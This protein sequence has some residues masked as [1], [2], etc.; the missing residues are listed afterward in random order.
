MRSVAMAK[1]AVDGRIIDTPHFQNILAGRLLPL[2]LHPTGNYVVQ[3]LLSSCDDK[4]EFDSWFE[5]DFDA[6][7]EDILAAGNTGVVLGVAQACG[8]LAT[9]QHHFMGVR[10]R[11]Y[12][13]YGL[14]TF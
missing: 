8:R 7:V 11:R 12:K 1:Q 13:H 3:K 9:K 5:K 14:M 10:S 6:G 2:S 4:S